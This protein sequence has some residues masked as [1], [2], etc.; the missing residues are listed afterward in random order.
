[1]K[2]SGGLRVLYQEDNL[3]LLEYTPTLARPLPYALEPMRLVRW[4][5]FALEFLQKGSFRVYC[6]E[7]QGR[8]AAYCVATPGGRRLPCAAKSDIV[9]GP[10]FVAPELRGRGYGKRI[11]SLTLA[12][13]SYPYQNAYAWVEKK[14]TASVRALQSC[15][16]RQIG[17]LN[18]VGV[19]R[20]LQIVPE[21]DDW[22]Y[23]WSKRS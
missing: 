1:M 12:H 7:V 16:F 23:C 17:Q 10:F 19:M 14:N 20:R 22:I 6:L 2:T 11:L 5:R 21:G 8:P 13:C 3:R 15:G 9:L 4:V 18:V